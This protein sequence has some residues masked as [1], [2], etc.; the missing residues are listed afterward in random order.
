M[1]ATRGIGVSAGLETQ[2]ARRL[3]GRCRDLGY[4]SLWS[5]DEPHAP[6]LETLAAFRKEAPEL[7]LGVGV[8]PLHRNPPAKI[9]DDIER[10]GIDPTNLWIGFG[11]GTL[12]PQLAAVEDAVQELRGLLP[13]GARIAVGAM[14][15]KLCELGGSIADAVLLNWMP[16]SRAAEAKTWVAAGAKRAGRAV[17]IVA[18]YVR[19][20]LGPEGALQ[21]LSEETF[22][23]NIN[24]G[25]RRHFADLNVPVGSVGVSA[26]NRDDMVEKLAPYQEALDLPIARVIAGASS[27]DVLAV[28][29]AAA[30]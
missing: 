29:E 13:R 19:V 23:R 7:Q 28:A 1:T 25:H 11:S 15:P 24:E 26:R 6:G 2:D 20:A 8:L 5:N 10:L 4:A 30:P 9:A 14:R 22:Y 17:P 3:A 21:L 12:R 16:P 18:S 27:S